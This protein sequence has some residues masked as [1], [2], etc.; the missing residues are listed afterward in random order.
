MDPVL[1]RLRQAASVRALSE[2]GE[3][4]LRS[5]QGSL[6]GIQG[7]IADIMVNA[8]QP[9]G[10][11]KLCAAPGFGMDYLLPLMPAFLERFPA[12]MPDW[13][14]DNRPVDLIAGG[15]YFFV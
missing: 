14:F 10:V 9:A 12:V 6:D 15:S 13:Y 5:V 4:F 1:E 3:R 2:A 11:L 7:A 8:G